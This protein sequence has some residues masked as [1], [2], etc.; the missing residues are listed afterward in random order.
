LPLGK[1]GAAKPGQAIVYGIR[2][3]HIHLSDKGVEAEV[4]VV[5][6]TGSET[7][8]V[9]RLKGEEMVCVFRE[10]ITAK[11]GETIKILPDPDL[12]HLFDAANG[13]RID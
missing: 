5:E 9:V 4:V 1:L 2:P 3:E 12:V 8:V 11:P 6:P 10:R 13:K 7:Q